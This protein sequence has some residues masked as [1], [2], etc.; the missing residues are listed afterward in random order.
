MRHHIQGK[1]V[2]VNNVDKVVATA[3]GSGNCRDTRRASMCVSVRYFWRGCDAECV[4]FG[5]N[6]GSIVW[7]AATL[8]VWLRREA[9]AQIV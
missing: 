8:C 9:I 6:C 3:V 5:N 1:A 7:L 2:D 4:P